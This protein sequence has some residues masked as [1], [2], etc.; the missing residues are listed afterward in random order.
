MFV[1][2]AYSAHKALTAQ[3]INS[4][5]PEGSKELIEEI[6]EKLLDEGAI[7]EVIAERIDTE[8]VVR[9]FES[10]LG[11]EVLSVDNE[12]LREWPFTFAMPTY[13]LSDT[14][15]EARGT[16]DELIVVQ[17]II[18]MLVK[19]RDGLLVIDFKTDNVTS[20]Q[21]EEQAKLYRRQLELYGRAAEAVLR[22]KVAG[23]WLYFLRPGCAIEV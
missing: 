23:G 14:M 4:R 16:R 5:S 8:S 9:F 11:Q 22:E 3:E 1:R 18:D 12:V 13:E 19:K 21:V 6:K 10:E 17:G 2:R 20:E 7:S 15:D